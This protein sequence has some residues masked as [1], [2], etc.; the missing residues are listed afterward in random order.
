MFDHIS[1]TMFDENK[2]LALCESLNKAGHAA[3]VS[4]VAILGTRHYTVCWND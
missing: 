2:A 1:T 4:C 3:V